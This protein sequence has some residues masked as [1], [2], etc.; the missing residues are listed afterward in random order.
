MISSPRSVLVLAVLAAL[1]TGCAASAD[2]AG[3]EDS[4]ADELRRARFTSLAAPSDPDLAAFY[5]AANGLENEYLGVYRFNKPVAEA[6]DPGAREKRI[7]G[8]LARCTSERAREKWSGDAGLG[9]MDFRWS[10][11]RILLRD[12]SAGL[13]GA[14]A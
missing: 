1:A 14:R 8:A 12:I 3:G 10:N 7:K 11:A 2:P 5:G 9:Q 4:S 6:T 13:D